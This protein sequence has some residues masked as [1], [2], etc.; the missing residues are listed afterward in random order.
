MK[1]SLL[2]TINHRS[3]QY[4]HHQITWKSWVFPYMVIFH[5]SVNVNQQ[6]AN[7]IKGTRQRVPTCYRTGHRPPPAAPR[8]R[9]W[10]SWHSA[11]QPLRWMQRR[12]KNTV[13]SDGHSGKKNIHGDLMGCYD[14]TGIKWNIQLKHPWRL[15]MDTILSDVWMGNDW[16]II[17]GDRDHMGYSRTNQQWNLAGKYQLTWGFSTKS[18]LIATESPNFAATDG[19]L[20]KNNN[21]RPFNGQ[22]WGSLGHFPRKPMKVELMQPADDP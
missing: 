11:C 9:S 18:C 10:R 21:K 14:W 17:H 5:S 3:S 2:T 16:N 15:L 22:T 1:K 13:M 19:D 20:S 6:V 12:N 7:H 4:N 8:A